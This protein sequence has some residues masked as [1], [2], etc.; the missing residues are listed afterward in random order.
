M[1]K[2][3][4]QQTTSHAKLH[5][6]LSADGR[7][8]TVIVNDKYNIVE[9]I[10]NDASLIAISPGK[11]SFKLYAMVPT[12]L[13]PLLEAGIYEV[14]K[15]GI[16]YLKKFVKTN[17]EKLLHICIKPLAKD[18]ETMYVI[19]IQL[20]HELSKSTNSVCCKQ[21][22]N[23]SHN[24]PFHIDKYSLLQTGIEIGN[25]GLWSWDL[26]NNILYWSK[27][28][29]ALYGLKEG[30][31]DNTT[32]TFRKFVNTDDWDNI[33]EKNEIC[34]GDKLYFEYQFRITRKDGE[35][36]N[37]QAK[38]KK[39]FNEQGTL[40]KVTGVN[41][42][43]TDKVT[44]KE[45]A[46]LAEA[47]F[48]LALKGSTQTIFSQDKNLKHT[49]IFNSHPDFN[50]N[51][52]IGKS[53]EEIHGPIT[54]KRLTN[55]KKQ[56][57]ISGKSLHDEVLVC[58]NDK[59]HYY[60]V[61]V[62]PTFN[63]LGE[64]EGLTGVALDITERKQ[65]EKELKSVKEQLEIT[66][67]NVPA[68]IQL[69]NQK[70]ELLYVNEEAAR[71]SGFGSAKEMMQYKDLESM[72]EKVQN[73][74]EVFTETDE[75]YDLT[76]SPTAI[77]LKTGKAAEALFKVLDKRTNT[78]KWVLSKSSV[79]QDEVG[80]ISLVISTNIDITQQK[81]AEE[82]LKQNEEQFRSL[83]NSIP[84]LAWITDANGYIYWYN[85]RWYD[86]TGTTI[87]Q[88]EGWGWQ[89]IHHPDMVAD[90]TKK[91]KT[92]IENKVPYEQTF[93]LKSKEGD[94]RWFLTRAIPIYDANN[95]IRQWFGTNTDVT[96]Q[97]N[98]QA[99]LKESEEKFRG[100]AETLP[101]LVWI[102]NEKGEP[103]YASSSWDEYSGHTIYNHD[104]WD[105][106]VHPNDKEEI[107]KKWT[108]SLATGD[109]YHAEARLKNKLGEYRWHVVEGVAL[110]NNE[111]KITKWIGA[112]TDIQEQK[113]KEQKKDEFISIASHE[114]K[115]PITTAKGYL[116]LLLMHLGEDNAEAHLFATK[117]NVAVTRLHD[118][119]TELL[120]A[121]KIQNG[122]LNYTI[123]N[124]GFLSLLKETTEGFRHSTKSHTIYINCE[125]EVFVNGD[126][127]RL[128]QVLI[129][130]L[131]NAIKYS[132]SSNKVIIQ[133]EA[134]DGKNLQISVQDFGV[135][136]LKKHQERIF[137][138]YYRVQEHAIFFQG[139]GI[140]LYISHDIVKRHKGTM[141]VESEPN[142][143][144]TF[145][146]S[147]PLT[148][149]IS[150]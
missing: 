136:I 5:D 87:E 106:I 121:S 148:T 61:L 37:I 118:L 46:E 36:R 57:L 131:T 6:F 101:H 113:L 22:A 122:K 13:I 143:G 149:T 25:I 82:K 71:M 88:M 27:E 17:C 51:D 124:F 123:T 78:Y 21:A 35:Q 65:F 107:M 145:Y 9:V 73:Y 119:V 31:F 80:N 116:E 59:Y 117:A 75:P 48:K 45:N 137:D 52:I 99:A 98:I 62:E 115:T 4:G 100:L 32:E 26:Q 33:F 147:I 7:L 104:S 127:D 42:D 83:A 93:L 126:K 146:F 105:K 40:I 103:I 91:F 60:D 134:I 110:L 84:Q 90:V 12:Y 58:I 141:W 74:L 94:Y 77:S 11:L 55:L 64:V 102:T 44:A 86:Y 30:E 140:G 10:I 89:T 2:N 63:N 112:F 85:Q 29:E 56:A 125:T 114:M 3:V 92:A 76:K 24:N 39:I 139:L 129:N 41:I 109:T 1:E 54:A 150:N 53:D 135:G 128:Q 8:S 79:L 111:N 70:G 20:L 69:R 138:R 16:D 28:Q 130:L 96:E 38:S 66:F 81:V 15:K 34:S 132:P 18:S 14:K 108:H 68:A 50:A 97:L 120:D 43:I 23:Q 72:R 19:T 47:R 67:N 144:S 142:V 133:M 49:W 95:N